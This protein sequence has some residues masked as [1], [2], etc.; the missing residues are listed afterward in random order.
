[1]HNLKVSPF[2]TALV[3]NVTFIMAEKMFTL[4]FFA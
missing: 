2:S 3:K 4:I 1:M